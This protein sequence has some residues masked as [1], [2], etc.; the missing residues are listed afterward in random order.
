MMFRN[1]NVHSYNEYYV[2]RK[3]SDG[4]IWLMY[5]VVMLTDIR[6]MSSIAVNV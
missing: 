5:Y 3:S 2:N 4:T 6:V 1:F